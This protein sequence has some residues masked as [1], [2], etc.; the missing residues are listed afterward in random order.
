MSTQPLNRVGVE[1]CIAL[2]KQV[3]QAFQVQLPAFAGW[4]VQD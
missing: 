4:T 3:F 2:A 1:A